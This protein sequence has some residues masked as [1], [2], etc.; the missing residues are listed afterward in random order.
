MTQCPPLLS[1]RLD[2]ARPDSAPPLCAAVVYEV[3][4]LAAKLAV[5]RLPMTKRLQRKARTDEGAQTAE[6]IQMQI[7]VRAHSSDPTATPLLL[8]S[9]LLFLPFL[10][11]CLLFLLLLP[12]LRLL[13]LLPP[14]HH[15][16]AHTRA[17]VRRC[18]GAVAMDHH[19]VE[20]NQRDAAR[21][22]ERP[23]REAATPKSQIHAD[24]R[25]LT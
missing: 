3:S 6:K 21:K 10:F 25:S 5:S 24:P 1:T 12:C 11:P 17:H 7:V 2:C 15:S 16:R 13:F 18:T 14:P 9:L 4:R 8:F 20:A 23:S 22:S 19:A